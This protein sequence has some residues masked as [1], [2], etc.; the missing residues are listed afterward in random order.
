[1]PSLGRVGTSG[2]SAAKSGQV[3]DDLLHCDGWLT[4]QLARR[5]IQVSFDTD[6][7]DPVPGLRYAIELGSHHKCGDVLIDG[8][9][10]ITGRQ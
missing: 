1:M 5:H 4:H 9:D 6:H 3:S 8:A 7:N 2:D 10:F